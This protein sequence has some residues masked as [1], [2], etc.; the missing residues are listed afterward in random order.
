MDKYI[1]QLILEFSKIILP[2]FGAITISDE[3]SG[4]LM[5]QEFLQYDDGKL[6]ALLEEESNMNLQ[7]AKNAVAKFIRELKYHL[8]KGDTY[9]IYQ[10]GEFSK[11]KDTYTFSGNIK[12]GVVTKPAEEDESPTD[13]APTLGAILTKVTEETPTSEAKPEIIPEDKAEDKSEPIPPVTEEKVEKEIPVSVPPTEKAAKTPAKKK[14]IY[15]EKDTVEQKEDVPPVPVSTLEKDTDNPTDNNRN[16]TDKKRRSPFFWL[17]TLL[18]LF[19]FICGIIVV[20]NYNKVENYMGWNKFEEPQELAPEE[21]L[22]VNEEPEEIP[23]TDDEII[24]EAEEVAEDFQSEEELIE[25]EIDDEIIKQ[26]TEKA[27]AAPSNPNNQFHVITGTFEELANANKMVEELKSK[28]L[29]AKVIGPFNGMQYVSSQSYATHK[30]AENN[31][32]RIRGISGGAWIYK[33]K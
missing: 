9:S 31:I 19:I 13:G 14:N 3:E 23:A 29:D 7:E 18:L 27:A 2:D 15:I 8:D 33:S 6:A 20:F 32:E 10:L 12:T 11:V 26:I 28:G 1:K 30:E 4:E 5:F 16:E 25:S 24:E 22:Q 21:D 17:V